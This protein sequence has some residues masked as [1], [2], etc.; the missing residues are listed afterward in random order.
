VGDFVC[1]A[2]V[3]KPRVVLT[4]GHCV[5]SG[6]GT[7]NGWF[8]NFLFVPAFRDGVAPYGVWNWSVTATT[9]EWFSGGGTVPNEADYAVIVVTDSNGYRLGDI[10]GWFGWQT[11]SLYPNH[12]TMLGYPCN[13]DSC[14]KMHQVDSESFGVQEPNTVVYGADMGG[15][16]SGGPWIQNFGPKSVGQIGGPSPGRN[17]VVGVTS[18]GPIDGGYMYLGSSVL[19]DRFVNLLNLACEKAVG[20]C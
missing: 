14:Q 17:R 4:A 3:I 16:V 8:T 5:H 6:D 15:G 20:N 11:N 19:D 9:G 10:T 1:S 13:L 2:A 7:Q 12:V 18:Y